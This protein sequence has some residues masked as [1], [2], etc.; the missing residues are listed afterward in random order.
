MRVHE[1]VRVHIQSPPLSKIGTGV[2][3]SHKDEHTCPNEMQIYTKLGPG[4]T[5]A[6]RSVARL[7]AGG[8]GRRC[9]VGVV[10]LMR[11]SVCWEGG[12]GGGGGGAG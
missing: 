2:E 3:I 7:G 12:R 4:H 6:T 1:G 10:N 5:S 9:E 8:H 11:R